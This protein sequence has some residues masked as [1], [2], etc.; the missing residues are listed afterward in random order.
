MSRELAVAFG[1][2]RAAYEKFMATADRLRQAAEI[3][4][5]L[6][7]GKAPIEICLIQRIV[8]LHFGYSQAALSSRAKHAQLVLARHTAMWLCRVL[9]P[10]CS[11]SALGRAFGNRDHGTVLWGCQ[12][13]GERIATDDRFAG[14]IDQLRAQCEEALSHR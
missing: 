9:V 6:G 3:E 8:A 13:I 7:E 10:N 14:E 12:S 11:F 1:E 5:G 2:F 4:A